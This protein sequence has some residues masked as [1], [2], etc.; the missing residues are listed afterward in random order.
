MKQTLAITR[1]ELAAYFG[2]PMA[3][4]F[5]GVFLAATLFVFF[6]VDTCAHCSA[7]CPF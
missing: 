2:S 5:V 4:I 3:L 1:K 7:G 6:W